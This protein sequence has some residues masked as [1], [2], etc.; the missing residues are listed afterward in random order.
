[1]SIT[2]AASSPLD[3]P[4]CVS[5]SRMKRLL[6][7]VGACFAIML[8]TPLMIVVAGAIAVDSRGPILF[9]QN[10]TGLHGR[11]F[12]IFKFRTM[13]VMEDGATIQQATQK[14]ARVTRV[15]AFLRRSSI[16]E[17]PQLFNVVRGDMSLVGPRPH[18]LA[19]DQHFG[20]LIPDYL[21]RFRARPGIT[22]LAQV[23][24]LRGEIRSLEQM[25]ERVEKDN[26]YIENWSIWR[27]VAILV[28]TVV[29]VPFHRNAY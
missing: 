4:C 22:G 8:L 15:G 11:P 1:M 21:E 9:R 19:H 24:G 16:D 20:A 7:F 26:D 23:R 10:R 14:D 29:L 6:D 2:S 5:C 27:D 28:A 13:T 25:E 18:A 12:R 3:T 17:L